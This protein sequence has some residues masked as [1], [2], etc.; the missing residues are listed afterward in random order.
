MLWLTLGMALYAEWVWIDHP[1]LLDQA[2]HLLVYR[3]GFASGFVLPL[4]WWLT[5][6]NNRVH[7]LEQKIERLERQL[8]EKR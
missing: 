4:F 2:P 3:A 1:E 5:S 6:V 7:R 8:A